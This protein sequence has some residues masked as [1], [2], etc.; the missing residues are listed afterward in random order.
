M[1]YIRCLSNPE[2]LYVYSD[3]KDVHIIHHVRPPHSSGWNFVIP[4]KAFETAL[5]KFM[6]SSG[7]VKYAGVSVQELHINKKT[8]A[9]IEAEKPCKRGCKRI[10][11]G[12]V[13]CRPCS[14]KRL[15]QLDREP[16]WF[17]IRLSYKKHFVNLWQVT[18]D[19]MTSRFRK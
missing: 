14:R 1:S 16:G 3:G 13:P 8:G 18:F 4:H 11:N 2:S 15:E 5:N 6:K 10:M 17:C 19:Y 7:P 12:W 9:V